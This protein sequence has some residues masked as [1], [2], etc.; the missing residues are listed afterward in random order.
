[1]REKRNALI[2]R[3]KNKTIQEINMKQE[4]VQKPFVN[5]TVK[6]PKKATN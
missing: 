5:V 1:V 6:S 2:I 4:E 3:Q